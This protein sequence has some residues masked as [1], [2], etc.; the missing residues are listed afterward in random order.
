VTSCCRRL[1]GPAGGGPCGRLAGRGGAGAAAA[2]G[3]CGEEI[4]GPRA[5]QLG[6][7]W[8]ALPS[9]QVEERAA[10]LARRPARDPQLARKA[11]ASLRTEL[12]PP[13]LPW[14]AALGV[15][16]GAQLWALRRRVSQ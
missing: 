8:E 11:T 12:G 2:A 15:E 1:G 13:R 7:A 9:E 5:V 14:A 10:E 3:I 4:S 16:R 6:L